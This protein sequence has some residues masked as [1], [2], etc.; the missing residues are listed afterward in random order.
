MVVKSDTTVSPELKAELT[1]ACKSLE[2]I[3]TSLKDWHPGSG[4]KV[5]DLVH[6]SLF[7]LI[8]GRSKVLPT[9]KVG[10]QNCTEYIGKGEVVKPPAST[11]TEENQSY[12]YGFSGNAR[13]KYWSQDFQWLPCDVEFA[14]ERDIKIISYI[15]NLHPAPHRRLYA[16]IESFISKSIPLWDR[17]LSSIRPPNTGFP[18]WQTRINMESTEYEFPQGMNRP[19]PS[20]TDG[21]E[22]REG[23]VEGQL[24]DTKGSSTDSGQDRGGEAEGHLE[25]SE[26]ESDDETESDSE[27]T[28]DWQR[29]TRVLIKPEPKPERYASYASSVARSNRAIDF[30]LREDFAED[31]I[32]VIVK[33]ANIELTPTKPDYDGGSWHIEGQLNE[34]ICASALYYYDSENVTESFLAF[35]HRVENQALEERAYG[36]VSK[37]P[38]HHNSGPASPREPKKGGRI[39]AYDYIWD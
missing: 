19:P 20:S 26:G 38:S 32:Q 16:V 27:N 1:I 13:T 22:D 5:L 2:D 9:G 4:D 23:E 24:E 29:A 17:V 36:Q 30:N 8:Y 35:R 7:P 6:P 34:H 21:G 25:E 18:R 14:E 12:H 10:L 3:P 39:P 11:D 37:I 15:N 28:E 33:L 31:G